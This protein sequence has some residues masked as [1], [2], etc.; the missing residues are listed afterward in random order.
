MD[1]NWASVIIEVHEGKMEWIATDVEGKSY[2]GYWQ[3]AESLLTEEE[4]NQILAILVKHT[5][6]LYTEEDEEDEEDE[7]AD[8]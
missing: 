5:P 8:C 2:N 3:T 7:L 6:D 4:M 1:M